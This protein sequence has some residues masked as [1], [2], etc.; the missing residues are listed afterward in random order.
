MKQKICKCGHKRDD[1]F[2]KYLKYESCDKCQCSD[3]LTHNK[4]HR[5]DKIFVVYG[6]C[7]LVLFWGTFGAVWW[8]IDDTN[9]LR[10]NERMEMT[11][12][13]FGELVLLLFFII[14]LL[15]SVPF[16]FLIPDYYR[17]K[18]RRV[19]PEDEK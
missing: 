10:E 3:Y 15:M 16:Y 9:K 19:Y 14:V 18:R 6:V 5:L 11:Y 4:P 12:S 8:M 7:T 13:E 2:K 1:H 17:E